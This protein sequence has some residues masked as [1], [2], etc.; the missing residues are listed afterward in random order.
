M[1]LDI[2][3]F[4][5]NLSKIQV[6]LKS[7]KNNGHFTCEDVTAFMTILAQFFLG[8]EMFQR[9]VADKIKIHILR[10]VTLFQKS[11][12]LWGNVEKCGGARDHRW[13]Y[14]S[15]LRSGLVRLHMSKHMPASVHP[16]T[17]TAFPQQVWSYE[18]TSS[19]LYIHHC[20]S[21]IGLT[22]VWCA[23]LQC[24]SYAIIRILL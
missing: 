6:L 24:F 23:H 18:C 11:C 10:S 1:K 8:W 13:Q 9:K 12:C 17:F 2:W 19:T 5:E 3:T 4:F 14:G 16:H 21:C 15:V 22:Q 20:P 7:D